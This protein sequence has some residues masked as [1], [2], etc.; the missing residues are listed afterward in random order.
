M[1]DYPNAQS[2]PAAAV[3]V[4]IAPPLGAQLAN[5]T[6]NTTTLL[7]SGSGVV[8]GL[9][10]NTG[11]TTSTVKIYDGLTAAGTLLG[12]FSS[13]AQNGVTLPAG[14]FPFTT[15]LCVVTA[16]AAAADITVTYK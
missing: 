3:P 11:G 12:T 7:K 5:I 2:D 9:S 6:T 16:G 15:G 4:W 10:I 13:T 1:T 14:G 8:S